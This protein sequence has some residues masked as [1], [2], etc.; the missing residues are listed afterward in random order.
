MDSLLLPL[1]I[2]PVKTDEKVRPEPEVVEYPSPAAKRRK[3]HF[4]TR[5]HLTS[6]LDVVARFD[7]KRLQFLLFSDPGGG[8]RQIVVI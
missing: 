7:N 6:K 5:A 1:N 3:V 2:D 8:K 4:A